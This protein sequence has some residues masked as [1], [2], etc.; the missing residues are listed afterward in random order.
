MNSYNNP[1]V[2]KSKKQGESTG[3]VLGMREFSIVV[4]MK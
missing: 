2:L 3:M 1:E 4:E